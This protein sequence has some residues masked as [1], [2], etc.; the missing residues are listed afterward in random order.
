VRRRRSNPTG[1]GS[2]DSVRVLYRD[3]NMQLWGIPYKMRPGQQ[4]RDLE[5][6]HHDYVPP[7]YG[8]YGSKQISISDWIWLGSPGWWGGLSNRSIAETKDFLEEYREYVPRGPYEWSELPNGSR[9]PLIDYESK[10]AVGNRN[11]SGAEATALLAGAVLI[12]GVVAYLVLKPSVP[13]A[14]TGVAPVPLP[15]PAAPVP[16]QPDQPG[17]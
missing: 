12:A 11:L 2:L 8:Y 10:V 1:G 16:Y 9:N 15:A 3:G 14:S 4:P 13:T 6:A 7:R 17:Y 5:R